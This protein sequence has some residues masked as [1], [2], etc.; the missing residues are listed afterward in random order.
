[1]TRPVT[2]LALWLPLL[3][4]P[5]PLAIALSLWLPRVSRPPTQRALSLVDWS[6]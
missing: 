5:L 4:L 2:P 6:K 3:A 1:V